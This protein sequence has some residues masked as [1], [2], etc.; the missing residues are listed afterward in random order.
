MFTS[1]YLMILSAVTNLLMMCQLTTCQYQSVF[2][3]TEQME[4]IVKLEK[5]V[6]VEMKKHSVKLEMALN[7]IEEYV[8]QVTEVNSQCI[9]MSSMQ[10]IF[11]ICV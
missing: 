11:Y 10:K 1:S 5:E 7:S 2:S 4:K 6:V 3:S 9:C 8:S